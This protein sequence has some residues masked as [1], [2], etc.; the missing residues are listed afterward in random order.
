MEDW[1]RYKQLETEQREKDEKERLALYKKLSLT[2]RSNLDDDKE[3]EEL[4]KLEEEDDDELAFMEM[5]KQKRITEIQQNLTNKWAGISFG[6]V[7]ELQHSN[8]V[9]AIEEE[10]AKVTVLI[11]VYES[12]IDACRTVNGCFSVLAGQYKYVKFCKITASEAKVSINFKK[13]ALPAI[14]AYKDKMLIG[15]FIRVSDTLGDDFFATDL[16][17][18]LNE[19]CLLTSKFGA[20][21]YKDSN[22]RSIVD[23]KNLNH[24][25]DS[26][27]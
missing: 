10:N 12:N 16:E 14:L 18:F 17:G 19:Y 15:N 25:S 6:K 21:N 27:E 1:R 3:K 13:N 8:Y 22:S 26:D 11:H 2:C 20:M 24:D 9:E 7:M 23:S 4:E 5:Y